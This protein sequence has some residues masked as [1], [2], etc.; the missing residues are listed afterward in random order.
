L[1]PGQPDTVK[2]P[3]SQAKGQLLPFEDLS[4]ENFQRLSV[5]LLKSLKVVSHCQ[6]FGI[7]GQGQDGI[8][9][10]A[11]TP[12]DHKLEVWQCKRYIKTKFQPSHVKDAVKLFMDGKFAADTRKFVIVTSAPTEDSA[13]ADAEIEAA[14]ILKRVGI[15]FELIGSSGLTALL[16]DHP[17]IIDDF[18]QREWVKECC[19]EQAL[20]ALVERLTWEEISSFRNE[21]RKLYGGIFEQTD[22][23]ISCTDRLSEGSSRA[24]ILTKRW[25]MPT[26]LEKRGSKI[27]RQDFPKSDLPDS[28]Q[29][30]GKEASEPTTPSATQLV[31]SDLEMSADAFLG[32]ITRGVILGEP[33]HGKST[34]LRVVALD[35]LSDQP[36]LQK[37]VENFG[38]RLPVW[39]P[40][41]FL[42]KMFSQGKSLEE[43]AVQWLHGKAGNKNL[44][45]L[46]LKA[47]RDDRLLLLID[48]LDEWSRQ[49]IAQQAVTA[50]QGF[51]SNHEAAC[52]TTARPLGYQRLDPLSGNWRHATIRELLTSQQDAMAGKIISGIRADLPIGLQDLEIERFLRSLQGEGALRQIAANPL[53]L[54]GLLSLWFQKQ[55]LPQSRLDVCGELVRV[56]L[57]QHRMTRAAA[58]ESTIGERIKDDLLRD[59][60]ARLAFR[61]HQSESGAFVSKREAMTTFAEFFE[62][63]EGMNRADAREVARQMLPLSDQ[64]IGVLSEATPEGD[65][66]FIHRIFQEFLAAEHLSSLPLVDQIDYCKKLTGDTGWHH[67][68]LFLLQQSR[69]PDE[70]FELMQAIESVPLEIDSDVHRKLLLAKAVFSG[71]RLPPDERRKRADA[72]LDEVESGTWM[73]LRETLLGA[74]LQ[75]PQGTMVHEMLQE[76]L[77]NW[78]PMPTS[79]KY[80]S[81]ASSLENWPPCPETDEAVWH[82]LNREEISSQIEAAKCLAKRCSGDKIWKDRL[83]KR[84]HQ[85]LS[86]ES[87]AAVLLALARGWAADEKVQSI[88]RIGQFCEDSAVRLVATYG[89]IKAKKHDDAAK[90]QLLLCGHVVYFDEFFIEGVIEGWPGDE[91][92]LELSLK[93]IASNIFDTPFN[94]SSGIEI[95]M[96]GYPGDDRVANMIGKLLLGDNASW[97]FRNILLN[98]ASI[99]FLGHPSV[100][101]S[102]KIALA[103]RGSFDSFMHAPLCALARTPESK[104]ILLDDIRSAHPMSFHSAKALQVG[105]GNEDPEVKKI[106]QEFLSDRKR[107]S[108]YAQFNFGAIEDKAA[109]RA[110]LLGDLQKGGKGSRFDMLVSGLAH[111]RTDEP[112]GEIVDAA[113]E[114]FRLEGY[115][116]TDSLTIGA[117]IEDFSDHSDV[118]EIALK[119]ITHP[120]CDLRLLAKYFGE[121]ESFRVE[122][123]RRC[124]SLPESLRFTIAEFSRQRAPYDQMY[125]DCTRSFSNECSPDVRAM[126]AIAE[127]EATRALQEE[128]KPLIEKFK[129]DLVGYGSNYQARHE[130]AVLGLISLGE[131]HQIESVRDREGE[132]AKITVAYSHSGRHLLADTLVR[133][134]SYLASLPKGDPLA[135]LRNEYQAETLLQ[136]ARNLGSEMVVGDIL[137]K[138]V[139]APSINNL[140]LDH[141]ARSNLPGWEDACFK[142]MGLSDERGL[143][144]GMANCE[145]AIRVL[146]TYSPDKVAMARRLEMKIYDGRPWVIHALEALS[147]ICPTSPL[148]DGEWTR[149][150]ELKEKLSDLPVWLVALKAS[151]EDFIQW[152]REKISNSNGSRIRYGSRTDWWYILRR[153]ATDPVVSRKLLEILEG[154]PTHNEMASIPWL[155]RGSNLEGCETRLNAWATRQWSNFKDIEIAPFGYDILGSSVEPILVALLE[156]LLTEKRFVAK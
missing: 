154:D 102:A 28:S 92:I 32:D 145:T 140:E 112:D 116:I 75:A 91:E 18:F 150:E 25:V 70:T 96:R 9:L 122:V 56:L 7:P 86:G 115:E 126:C 106:F 87:I 59:A 37:T 3:P 128:A 149:F 34:L 62:E 51:L 52:L 129:D 42:S 8:D 113:L 109:Y 141:A 71:I 95:A 108:A 98:K 50:I 89:L 78:F 100:R 134:W 15:E 147:R 63:S 58:S 127:A 138:A 61:I 137:N 82:L 93:S 64:V 45:K 103:K 74:V 47:M 43:A 125:R 111:V 146:N 148:I 55:S 118:K 97:D 60:I 88:F 83:L 77:E 101:S 142:A 11:R 39:L 67:V 66:Q 19:G 114:A 10:Y 30:L 99:S 139:I 4:F 84:L 68:L 44:S 156:I 152:V 53:L 123:F 153:T 94:E 132:A 54:I 27:I 24:P 104:K 73:P 38:D 13:L 110:A 12:D 49:E 151:S 46:V 40:F 21:L 143:S 5:R 76:R 144:V 69:R 80:A 72:F 1:I 105:W 26:I 31:E 107:N 57:N 16:K 36:V 120:E 90:R 22:S 2:K 117:L 131:L 41:P 17:K 35:L 29:R 124:R 119:T 130:A 135:Y 136:T 121:E 81:V 14:K 23:F 6:E 65:V 33:G 79:M 133:K 48:G 85:P 20:E 155:V